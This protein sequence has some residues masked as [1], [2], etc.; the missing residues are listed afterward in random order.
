MHLSSVQVEQI[1]RM[2]SAGFALAHIAEEV[3][4][5]VSS[6]R[7]YQS[8]S[9]RCY[10]RGESRMAHIVMRMLILPHLRVRKRAC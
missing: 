10:R 9:V 5:C 2:T 1:R 3:G 4:C 8:C 7:R 6:V